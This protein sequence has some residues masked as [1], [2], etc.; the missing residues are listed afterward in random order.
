M[1]AERARN[2]QKGL[3][4]ERRAVWWL[5]LKGYRILGSRVKTP[6]G[7]IDLLAKR[8]TVLV[9]VEVKTRPHIADAMEAIP[10]RQWQR[11]AKALEWWLAG[12]QQKSFSNKPPDLRFDAVFISPGS[13]P[14]HIRDAWRPG[15][16]K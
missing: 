6:V 5:R 10:P 12:H 14:R 13:W 8:G 7:E 15:G 2:Y 1:P 4:A 11:I 3:K 9:A 16:L